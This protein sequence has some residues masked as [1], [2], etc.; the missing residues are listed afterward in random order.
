MPHILL[1]TEMTLLCCSMSFNVSLWPWKRSIVSCSSRSYSSSCS[2]LSAFNCSR[3][4]HWTAKLN[5]CGVDKSHTRKVDNILHY[6]QGGSI[7]L[8]HYAMFTF[9]LLLIL[10]ITNFSL[11]DFEYYVLEEW[12]LQESFLNMCEVS[13]QAEFECSNC[14]QNSVVV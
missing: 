5:T 12:C 13:E 2:Q 9:C 4:V 6:I 11:F 14:K 1:M 7:K 3:F 8:H 10:I